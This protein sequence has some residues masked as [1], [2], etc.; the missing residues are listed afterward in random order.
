[1]S[2]ARQL[3]VIRELEQMRVLNHGEHT[4]VPVLC[5]EHLQ[6]RG[7]DFR[8]KANKALDKESN[9]YITNLARIYESRK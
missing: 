3:G 8:M 5:P 6:K 1:M 7:T 9:K 2:C 4:Y